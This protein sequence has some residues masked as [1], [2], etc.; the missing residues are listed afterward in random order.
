MLTSKQ[1]DVVYSTKKMNIKSLLT[2][3]LLVIN[4]INLLAFCYFFFDVTQLQSFILHRTLSEDLLNS[5]KKLLHPQNESRL[6]SVKIPQKSEFADCKLVYLDVGSNIG[7]QVRKLF[8][9]SRYPAAEVLPVFDQY[10]GKSRNKTTNLCA[11]GVEMNPIHTRRLTALEK[12]YRDTCGYS[13]RF[14]TETAASTFNG[15]IKFW[16][17]GDSSHNEWGASTNL[18]ERVR[19]SGT[20]RTSNALD[21][22]E[23]I[24]HEITPFASVVVMKLDIEGAEYEL[25]PRLVMKGALCHVDLIFMEQHP[26]EWASSKQQE[27]LFH[28]ARAL[29]DGETGC[30]AKVS[31][32]DDE[33]FLHDADSSMNTC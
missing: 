17:D 14:F 30:K 13:V 16:T 27:Q 19:K 21:L 29:F 12:H 3:V 5:S 8:E 9:P 22:A 11:I 15:S 2:I 31:L 10:F 6:T 18:P 1:G 20:N 26:S 24:I 25:L 4:S 33:S 32:I 7:V 23:F 28:H